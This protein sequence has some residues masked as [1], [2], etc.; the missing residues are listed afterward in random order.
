MIAFSKQEEEAAVTWQDRFLAMLPEIESRL[1]NEFRNVDADSRE[2]AV[3]EGVA[4]CLIS[5]LRLDEAGRAHV[6]TPFTLVLYGARH[7]RQ[8]R[9]AAGRMNPKDPLSRYGQLENGVHVDSKAGVW[10]EELV[11][12]DQASV[13]DQVATKLDVG[14]WFSTLTWRMKQIARDLAFGF[15]TSEAA[16]KHG[17]SPGRISQL[18]R[19][20]ER[21]WLEFQGEPLPTLV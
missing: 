7:V 20:L 8:G 3:C 10:I 2:E 13:S 6:A 9:P 17:V 18:R 1:H 21:S 4:H 19:S 14:A 11:L 15:S 12:D 16:T 5:Y